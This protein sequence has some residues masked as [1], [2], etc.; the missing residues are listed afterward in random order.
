MEINLE[1]IKNLPTPLHKINYYNNDINLYIKRDDLIDDYISG[2][3]W[4]KLKY[5]LNALIKQKKS[6]LLT[7][8]GAY[9]NHI[10]ACAAV[11]NRYNIKSIGVIRGEELNKNS[12]S[13]LQ[14]ATSQGMQLLFVDRETYS[15]RYEP[16]FAELL[17]EKYSFDVNEIF[18]VPEG[19]ANNLGEKGCAEI[20]NEI[21]IDFNYLITACGTGTT[22]LGM[23][24]NIKSHQKI[25]GIDVLKNNLDLENKLNYSSNTILL[26]EY[27]FGGYGKKNQILVDFIQQFY[28]QNK[29]KLDYVYTGKMMYAI[30]DLLN[31]NYF[32]PNSTIVALHTGGI[33]NA[34]CIDEI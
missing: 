6:T 24:K 5:N 17:C 7:V 34:N 32:S 1:L 19:G 20:V 3:K 14:F 30:F 28:I 11:A 25:I 21:N 33:L 9:S 31:K 26:H 8:G 27:H 23:S 16:T 22:L 29:I 4:R 18:F 2:N 12:N 13:N 15:R 10:M